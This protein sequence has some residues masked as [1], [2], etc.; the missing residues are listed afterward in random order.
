MFPN[1]L[2]DLL[3]GTVGVDYDASFQ[4]PQKTLCSV[5]CRVGKPEGPLAPHMVGPKGVEPLTSCKSSRHS[6]H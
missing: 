5:A 3:V 1:R 6:S 2:R 4:E